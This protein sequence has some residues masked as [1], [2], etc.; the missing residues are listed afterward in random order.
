MLTGSSVFV[1]FPKAGTPD[2]FGNVED[3]FSDPVEIENVLCAP[4]STSEMEES[5]P[6]GIKVDVRFYFPKT[7]SG[8]SLRGAK[9]A[10]GDALYSV[11]GEPQ[12]YMML[13]PTPWNMVVEGVRTDG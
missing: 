5:R 10:V 6:D 3:G 9:I 2:S 7:Y 12:S 13:C 8:K 4:I 1:Y 11:I